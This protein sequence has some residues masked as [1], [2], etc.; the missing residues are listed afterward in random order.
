MISESPLHTRT[1]VSGLQ[2]DL[3]QG[4]PPWHKAADL[5]PGLHHALAPGNGSGDPLPL[6]LVRHLDGD[7]R[8]NGPGT[9]TE[10]QPTV[11][12]GTLFEFDSVSTRSPACTWRS[13]VPSKA[14]APRPVDDQPYDYKPAIVGAGGIPLGDHGTVFN[15]ADGD[16]DADTP[17]D[18]TL[19]QQWDATARRQPERHPPY[20]HALRR[21]GPATEPGHSLEDGRREGDQHTCRHRLRDH[22]HRPLRRR[23][24]RDARGES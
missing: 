7:L 11:P 18:A 10:R 17:F 16:F 14:T 6:T 5:D 15:N 19:S 22:V 9:R 1:I 13:P 23:E 20:R 24:C 3:T 8:F 2:I 21:R 12:R 4:S